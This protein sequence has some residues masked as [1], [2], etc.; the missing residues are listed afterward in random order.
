LPKR[1]HVGGG[2]GFFVVGKKILRESRATGPLDPRNAAKGR[3]IPQK[4]GV[5]HHGPQWVQKKRKGGTPV[6]KWENA[7]TPQTTWFSKKKKKP[8]PA[9]TR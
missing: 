8:N 6:L 4:K 7:G 5:S 9:G 2:M 3:L 1:D